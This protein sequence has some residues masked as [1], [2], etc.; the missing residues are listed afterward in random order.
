MAAMAS[1]RSHGVALKRQA[2]L[3][4]LTGETLYGLAKR[5]DISWKSIRIWVEKDDAGA[6]DDHAQAVDPIQAHEAR[7]AALERRVGKQAL[8]LELFGGAQ[9][10]G[11]RPRSAPMSMIVG[12]AA[13]LSRKDAD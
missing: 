2:A 5:H 7:I 13:S 4:F 11:R 12:P 3:E 8:E 10:L 1:R 6:F 9:Q